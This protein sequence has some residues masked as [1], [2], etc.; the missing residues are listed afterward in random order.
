M[1]DIKITTEILKTFDQAERIALI[2]TGGN[3]AVC[4]HMA[5]D[6]YRHTGKFCFAPDS[7]NQTALGGDGDWKEPWLKYAQTS[8]DLIIAVTCRIASPLIKILEKTPANV[9]VLAPQQHS[10]MPTV[11]IPSVTYHEYECKALWTLYM[12]M[13]EN[14]VQLPRLK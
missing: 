2:G 4:Q 5:S 9:I 13:E 1:Y 7:V 11:V 8:S 3:L 14:G 6:I 12:L 10:V